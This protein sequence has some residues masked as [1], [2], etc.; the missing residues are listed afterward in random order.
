MKKLIIFLYVLLTISLIFPAQRTVVSE[1][2]SSNLCGYCTRARDGLSQLYNNQ[3]NVIPLIWQ[4]NGSNTS[5][6][7]NDRLSLIGSTSSGVPQI[8]FQGDHIQIGSSFS[9]YQNHFL[10]E[11]DTYL[12]NDT[13]VILNATKTITDSLI[14]IN[15]EIEVEE[16]FEEENLKLVYI[17]GYKFDN[18]Y[19]S[20]VISYEYED[21][22]AMEIDSV[23]SF[24]HSVVLNENWSTANLKYYVMI[25]KIDNN[26]S[27]I[28]QAYEIKEDHPLPAN[29]IAPINDTIFTTSDIDLLWEEG[30][31]TDMFDL[32]FANNRRDVLMLND[33]ALLF[34][35]M[36]DSNYSLTDLTTYN[37]YYWR[38]ISKK[39]NNSNRATSKINSFIFLEDGIGEGTID[40]P[41]Q[42]YNIDFYKIIANNQIMVD[43][44]YIQMLDF[45]F[46]EICI[47]HYGNHLPL[48]FEGYYDGNG[49]SISNVIATG[50]DD[51]GFFCCLYG[52]TVKNMNIINITIYGDY[53]VGGFAGL[54]WN[55]NIE[56]CYVSGNVTGLGK[57][58]GGLLGWSIEDTINNCHTNINIDGREDFTGG[59]VGIADNSII[60]NSSA[61]GLIEGEYYV[62]GLI[63]RSWHETIVENCFS[64]INVNGIAAVGGFV[65]EFYEGTIRE[66]YSEGEVQ[67][68]RKVGGFAGGIGALYNPSI[69]ENCYSKCN[70]L[71]TDV[72]YSFAGGLVGGANSF[73]SSSYVKNCFSTGAVDA[74]QSEN[75]GGLIGSSSRINIINCFWD[76]NTSN[77]ETSAAGIGK[78]TEEM[79]TLS[80][81]TNAG[82]DFEDEIE[83]GLE[84]IWSFIDGDYPH[85]TWEGFTN[86]EDSIQPLTPNNIC[87][88]NV[89]NGIEL[90]WDNV[91]FDINGNNISNITYLI[92]YSD[93]ITDLENYSLLGSSNITTFIDETYSENRQRFYYITAVREDNGSLRKIYRK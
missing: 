57:D 78:T 5:P 23:Y 76:I 66:C 87:V 62:G 41:Y 50:N 30:A 85:L 32:Y 38:V 29:L 61:S 48:Y 26:D 47:G 25:Q 93:E 64:D 36:S 43:K 54:A 40:N 31:N 63:G 39:D 58:V 86:G 49:K 79:M 44:A 80:T 59:L 19:F 17:L 70:V 81:Y 84:D 8:V 20:S 33:N 11:Y 89:D 69:M 37:T 71:S 75:L 9:A 16:Y 46:S 72:D 68:D 35:N 7:Y 3:P 2:F 28:Y 82:W 90:S 88:S 13:P 22:P 34:S 65:G 83:N 92:Y 67:A 77:Q 60:S 73:H 27:E 18:D 21:V 12:H 1:V 56:D 91:L 42:I 10:P 52:A 51:M 6:N 4:I 45:D 24:Q 53:H 74:V 14:I 55:S 15:S